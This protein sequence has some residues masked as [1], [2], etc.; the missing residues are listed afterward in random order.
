MNE[1]QHNI[2]L[3]I[4][5][6]AI[7]TLTIITA[8]RYQGSTLTYLFFSLTSTLL[9]INGIKKESIYFETFLGI[10]FWLG[11]W[12]KFSIRASFFNLTF[13]E[14]IGFY[15]GEVKFMDQALMISSIGFLGFLFA[16]FAR[17]YFKLFTYSQAPQFELEYLEKF[18]NQFRKRILS[19]F[20]FFSLLVASVNIYFGIYQKGLPPQTI[21]P[22]GLNRIITWLIL[23]GLS[24]IFSFFVF[25]DFKKKNF[26]II[27]S[28]IYLLD[29]FTTNVSLLSRGFVLNGSS[30]IFAHYFSEVR[31]KIHSQSIRIKMLI[32][33]LFMTM[34][35][36]SIFV[37][38]Y[39]RSTIFIT[40]V[41]EQEQGNSQ[42]QNINLFEIAKSTKVLFIDRWVG[43]EGAI[44]VASYTQRGQELWK[45]AW[46]EKFKDNG[47]SFYDK[48]LIQSPYA[49]QNL[50]NHHFI[51]L[52]GMIAF[53]YYSDSYYILFTLCF[54][55]GSFGTLVEYTTFNL[56]GGNAFFCS[57]IGQVAA[58]RYAH[59]GYV[60]AQ[61][62]LLFGTIFI[63]T[64]LFLII[65]KVLSFN[66]NFRNLQ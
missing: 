63:N 53:F 40:H 9:L 64:I 46:S 12:L 51:S 27:T 65:N 19:F 44:A 2:L 30:L 34:F 35:I 59:F 58:Y 8:T 11:F 18:Y 31:G 56:S 62:Y 21:L 28:I 26:G 33:A 29:C 5:L 48:N 66:K 15:N 43:I 49:N 38:N 54:I 61:S 47:T 39:F 17:Q 16:S 1:K 3:V 50:Q 13:F 23:F 52:P 10:F 24:S 60:P 20:V 45:K 7:S 55:A 4:I 41:Q 36:S 25:Y 37:V 42:F 22:M 6:L 14:A 32:I 57:L